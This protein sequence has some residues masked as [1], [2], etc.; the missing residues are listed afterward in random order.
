MQLS[1]KTMCSRPAFST[2]ADLSH[3]MCSYNKTVRKLTKV[4]RAPKKMIK[5]QFRIQTLLSSRRTCEANFQQKTFFDGFWICQDLLAYR[6]KQWLQSEK[7]GDVQKR[8]KT[9]SGMRATCRKK[10]A[11]WEAIR[12]TG[13]C[14]LKFHGQVQTWVSMSLH[15]VTISSMKVGPWIHIHWS[16]SRWMCLWL[17]TYHDLSDQIS[18]LAHLLQLRH[19]LWG[20]FMSPSRGSPKKA[21]FIVIRSAGVRGRCWMSKR[22]INL[23]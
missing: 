12:I 10:P 11:L 21:P 4:I 20:R 14:W 23:V 22:F 3:T 19:G 13:N 17:M 5:D 9:F 8:H 2:E 18:C 15:K 6:R 7:K 1:Y 16:G